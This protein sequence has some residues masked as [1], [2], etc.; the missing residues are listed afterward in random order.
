MPE[1][2]IHAP[3]DLTSQSWTPNDEMLH[4]MRRYASE[5]PAERRNLLTI[6]RDELDWLERTVPYQA[7]NPTLLEYAEGL[8]SDIARVQ[9]GRE[10]EHKFQWLQR[11]Q[12]D[13][14]WANPR[15]DT[16]DPPRF[17]F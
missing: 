12:N 2:H 8:R 1:E 7:G 9:A 13:H 3:E 16:G 10:I 4:D 6:L 15:T 5:H 11:W 17:R 14:E